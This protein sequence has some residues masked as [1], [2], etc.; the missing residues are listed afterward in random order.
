MKHT[1]TVEFKT[2]APLTE[3]QMNN[4]IS[5]LALQ[6]E[7]PQDLEGNEEEWEAREISFSQ[8]DRHAGRFITRVEG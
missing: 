7:E 8:T 2:D 6:L 1:I 3:R 4:L 5:I